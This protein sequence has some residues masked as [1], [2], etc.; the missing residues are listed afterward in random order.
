MHAQQSDIVYQWVEFE[1]GNII[2]TCPML[3][4]EDHMCVLGL[5][6]CMQHY[7]HSA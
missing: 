6:L 2:P 4:A 7:M 3:K 5:L 1:R